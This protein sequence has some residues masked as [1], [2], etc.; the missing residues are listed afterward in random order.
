MWWATCGPRAANFPP[1]IYAVKCCV[2]MSFAYLNNLGF[3]LTSRLCFKLNTYLKRVEESLCRRVCKHLAVST[4]SYQWASLTKRPYTTFFTFLGI[5]FV[6]DSPYS[7]LQSSAS[8]CNAKKLAGHKMHKSTGDLLS[9]DPAGLI[10]TRPPR[11]KNKQQL[12]AAPAPMPRGVGLH[13]SARRPSSFAGGELNWRDGSQETS[14]DQTNSTEP[15]T[16]NGAERTQKH[17]WHRIG[18]NADEIATKQPK[19]TVRCPV[20]RQD[21]QPRA[22]PESEERR[23]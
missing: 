8:L 22:V 20:Y 7:S 2:Y 4:A 21:D 11:H 13:S 19:I 3:G 18:E 1:L 10:S 14:D 6:T 5:R 9:V 15:M 17:G 23:R 12:S 16:R